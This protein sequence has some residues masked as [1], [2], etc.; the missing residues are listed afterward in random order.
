[1]TAKQAY[2]IAYRAQRMWLL[3]VTERQQTQACAD[4]LYSLDVH[5][6]R[7]NPAVDRWGM[8]IMASI[9]FFQ[10]PRYQAWLKLPEENRFG[11]NVLVEVKL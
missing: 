10:T 4:F 9:S 1:M 3:R 2:K 11:S 6:L 7:S 5:P 8:E